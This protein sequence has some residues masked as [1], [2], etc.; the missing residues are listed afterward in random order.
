MNERSELL[1]ARAYIYHV[2]QRM[3]DLYS[4]TPEGRIL[5]GKEKA[6]RSSQDQAAWCLQLAASKLRRLANEGAE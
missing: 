1:I 3:Q 6:R 2:R 4:E 5:V